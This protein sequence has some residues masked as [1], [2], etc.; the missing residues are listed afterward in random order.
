[1][2]IISSVRNCIEEVGKD[3]SSAQLGRLKGVGV[4]NQRETTI[5]WDCRTGES[6]GPA[7]VWCDGRTADLVARMIKVTPSNSKDDLRVRLS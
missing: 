2:E 6:L 7:L 1:M 4:T 5:L 3:L